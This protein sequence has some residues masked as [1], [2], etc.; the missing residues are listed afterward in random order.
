[1]EVFF[2]RQAP[3]TGI[4]PH[5]DGANFVQTSHLGLL[6]PD[7]PPGAVRIE[8][9]VEVRGWVEGKVWVCDTSFVH[10]TFNGGAEVRLWSFSLF[11]IYLL[12]C[13]HC[14]LLLAARPAC[15]PEIRRPLST[16][17]PPPPS[18]QSVLIHLILPNLPFLPPAPQDRVVL[19]LRHWHP[20]LAPLERVA[21]RFLFEALDDAAPGALAAAAAAV[22]ARVR[23][24]RRGAGK[25]GK[26]GGG[27][28]FGRR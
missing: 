28:G 2:A 12:Y 21:T 16:E 3:G 6:V 7:A 9:G 22:E 25:G 11:I 18:F 14:Y 10:S 5:T 24:L 13:I 23:A 19:I 17:P 20:E 8:A 4:A 15:T 27:G 26:G 1:L